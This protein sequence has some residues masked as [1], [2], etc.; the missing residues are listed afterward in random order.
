MVFTT[1]VFLIF[2]LAVLA[3]YYLLPARFRNA[4]LLFASY[5]YYM[6]AVPQ[7]GVLVLF[8]T[9]LTY[10]A[11]RFIA[12]EDA[13][14]KR[15]LWLALAVVLN[16]AVL[17]IF[18]YYNFFM[19]TVSA[20]T[21]GALQSAALT[22]VLPV[23][24]SFYTFQVLGYVI[25]VYNRKTEPE[26][27]FFTFALFVSFFPQIL[28]G[29]IGRA[30]ELLPQY[31]EAHDFDYTNLSLGFQRF[32]TGAFKKLVVA[33]GV[34]C[35]VNA[36]YAD[37]DK[38]TGVPTIIAVVLYGA[39]LYCD[40]SGYSDMAIGVGKM[41]GFTLRENFAAPYLATNI[42][43]FWKRWH[44]SLTSWFNDYI[45]TPLVWS[46]WANKL[47]F[48]K[49]WQE[50]KPHFALNLLIVFF[51]SGLWHGAAVTY[52][53]WGLLQGLL[54]VGEELVH[55][56]LPKKKG[57]KPSGFVNALKRTGVYLS[58]V[59]CLVFF[60]SESLAQAGEVFASLLR[61]PEADI[62][63][64]VF[65]KATA[66]GIL[67]TVGQVAFVWAVIALGAALVVCFD[68]ITDRSLAN[69]KA[70][71]IINSL[72]ELPKAG[73]W[74]AYWFM[75]IFTVAFYMISQSGQS[76]SAA[77]IYFGY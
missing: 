33:D 24:I 5:V 68:I 22:L 48:G 76:L 30:G 23:G 67:S 47:F 20:I 32:L 64:D 66:N 9:A 53:V 77:F 69:K 56:L 31:R 52:V 1:P 25:D 39:Q 75:A 17:F 18:K 57:A 3:V 29:P 26:K 49:R 45:F 13:Q 62:T 10:F 11:A 42:S 58:W 7:Y 60:R 46:R 63:A 41:L 51:I 36:V 54:R 65:M 12:K 55:R 4:F 38:W 28:A 21:G 15:R 35:L 27:D 19:D 44:M 43:G 61:F 70:A 34:G 50:H 59:L 6:Y 16:L 73:R 37:L 71:N 74:A 14:K 40:F 72:G 8:S 2:L